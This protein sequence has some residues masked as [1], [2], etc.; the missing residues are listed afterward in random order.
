MPLLKMCLMDLHAMDNLLIPFLKTPI[1]HFSKS[2]APLP[3]LAPNWKAAVS[4]YWRPVK[5]KNAYCCSP[6]MQ[7][8]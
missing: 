8:L 2:T 6:R 3:T 1:H 4:S 7:S 5:L